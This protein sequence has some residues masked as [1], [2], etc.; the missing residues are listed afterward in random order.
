MPARPS[1]KC[2]FGAGTRHVSRTVARGQVIAAARQHRTP[3]AGSKRTVRGPLARV[4]APRGRPGRATA[5]L[6]AA[7]G[8]ALLVAACSTSAPAVNSAPPASPAAQAAQPAPTS[9]AAS[10]PAAP[11]TPSPRPLPAYCARGGAELWAH[12]AD[13][14]WPGPTNTGP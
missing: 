12:L 6:A 7:F 4:A 10:S 3:G 11:A 9:P 8:A 2:P 13:C 14:G 1:V 5:L